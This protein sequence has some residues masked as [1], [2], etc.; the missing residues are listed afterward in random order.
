MIIDRMKKEMNLLVDIPKLGHG[1][2]NDGNTAR[3]VFQQPCLASQITGVNENLIRRLGI[4]LRTMASGYA[5]NAEALRAYVFET[6]ELYVEFYPWY[7]MPSSVHKILIHGADIIQNAALPIG[8]L[9][10][11][12]LESR[13][14]DFRYVRE[15]HARKMSRENNIEDLF[16]NLLFSSDPYI[17]SLSTKLPNRNPEPLCHESIALL[18]DTSILNEENLSGD[19]S[20]EAE[21]HSDE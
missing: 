3:R 9:S 13:N 6:A 16:N 2:T 17:S 19:D 20:D 5:I 10:E 1:T 12:A 15:H 21:T 4:I 7:C 18:L 8:M 11:E 14:K